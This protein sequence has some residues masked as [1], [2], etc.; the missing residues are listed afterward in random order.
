M[1]GQPSCPY[2]LAMPLLTT[3]KRSMAALYQV[4]PACPAPPLSLEALR[5]LLRSARRF[6][7]GLLAHGVAFERHVLSA[8]M[9][10]PQLASWVLA[11]LAGG[12][13]A[14]HSG[15]SRAARERLESPVSEAE[16]HALA[17]RPETSILR[18][19]LVCGFTTAG[20]RRSWTK[21]RTRARR[22]WLRASNEK[23]CGSTCSCRSSRPYRRK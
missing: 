8:L 19:S 6:E 21:W 5:G 11:L 15:R 2:Q 14:P 3:T 4:S 7:L 22:Q 20:W 17:S 1:A 13:E 16:P 18:P 23:S 9:G 12:G 10:V